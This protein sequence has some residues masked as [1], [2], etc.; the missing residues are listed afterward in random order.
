MLEV[1]GRRLGG[2]LRV[3]ALG[4]AVPLAERL[5]G[6]NGLCRIGGV[7]MRS[8]RL[9]IP[10]LCPLLLLSPPHLPQHISFLEQEIA[11]GNADLPLPRPREV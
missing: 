3:D 9:G 2:E 4:I 6:R 10:P 5:E 1:D 11:G 7:S 8:G